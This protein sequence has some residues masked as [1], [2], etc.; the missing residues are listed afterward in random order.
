MRV[1]KLFVGGINQRVDD[2]DL[3]DYFGRF[4]T[5][6]TVEL[7]KC[8]ETGRNRGFAFLYF[9]DSD[10]VDKLVCEWLVFVLHLPT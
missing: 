3:Q 5:V 7:M 8:K 1:K 9:A 10:V 4:G 6:E 2:S